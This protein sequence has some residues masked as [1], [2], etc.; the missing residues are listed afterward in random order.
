MGAIAVL[1]MLKAPG[2]VWGLISE[3]F[4]LQLFPLQRRLLPRDDE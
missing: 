2:G 4:G 3:R 1:I